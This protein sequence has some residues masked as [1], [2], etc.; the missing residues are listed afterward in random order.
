MGRAYGKM[1]ILWCAYDMGGY[2]Y[3]AR[4]RFRDDG[5][6]MVDMGMT[7]SLFHTSTGD[8]SPYGSRVGKG[9]V[10]APSHVHN[11]YWCLDFDID[12]PAGNVVEEFNY[13][14]DKPGALSG[15][16][17]WTPVKK[18]TSRPGSAANFRFWRVVNPASKNALGLSR[19]YEIVPGGNGIYRGGT[20]EKLTHA[21]VW[22]TK[23]HPEEHPKETRPLSAILPRYL[24]GESIDRANVVAW[25]G[26]HAHHVPRTEDW[27][28]MPVEWVG[29][30]LRPRDFLDASPIAPKK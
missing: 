24:N 6:I 19:S 4:W 20:D 9:R 16:H 5:S 13:V 30:A 27:Q 26:L 17:S 18:E 29:F 23:H 14:H 21:E 22:F 8:S 28:A 2:F 7:G 25:Y 12:G 15:K 3:I 10:F 1:L 11:L